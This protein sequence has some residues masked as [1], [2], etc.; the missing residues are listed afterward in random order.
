MVELLI[1]LLLSLGVITSD[2]D[3]YEADRSQQDLWTQEYE[4]GDDEL[5]GF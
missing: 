3:F 2:A 1:A 4:V 5:S